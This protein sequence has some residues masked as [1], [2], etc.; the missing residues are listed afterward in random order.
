MDG[1]ITTYLTVNVISLAN[2]LENRHYECVELF[3]LE[4]EIILGILNI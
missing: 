2:I 4:D 1:L 3:N